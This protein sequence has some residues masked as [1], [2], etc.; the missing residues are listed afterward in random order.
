MRIIYSCG[1]LL[2]L[3]SAVVFLSTLLQTNEPP[4]QGCMCWEN[5]TAY[6]DTRASREVY[7][8]TCLNHT[9]RLERPCQHVQVQLEHRSCLSAVLLSLL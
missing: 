5:T 3:S 4:V 7:K 9:H 2:R 1:K 6:N 8:V